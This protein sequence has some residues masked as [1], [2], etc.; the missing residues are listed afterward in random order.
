MRSLLPAWMSTAAGLEGSEQLAPGRDAGRGVLI[1][2]CGRSPLAFPK[3][4]Q[5]G[6]FQPRNIASLS[7][8]PV[9]V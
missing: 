2:G 3:E 8:H 7:K 4:L 9:L 6:F 1:L 5:V